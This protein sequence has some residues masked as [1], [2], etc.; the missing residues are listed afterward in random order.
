MSFIGL[1][2]TFFLAAWYQHGKVLIPD[3]AEKIALS[4]RIPE[5]ATVGEAVSGDKTRGET[6]SRFSVVSFCWANR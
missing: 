1:R 2:L 4:P 5:K 6:K 3:F